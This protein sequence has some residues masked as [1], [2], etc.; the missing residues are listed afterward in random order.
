MLL[1]VIAGIAFVYIKP[2]NFDGFAI[3]ACVI[4]VLLVIRYQLTK[5]L[6]KIGRNNSTNYAAN[7]ENDLSTLDYSESSEVL[8]EAVFK[9]FKTNVKTSSIHFL[10]DAG[11]E[12]LVT[13]FSSADKKVSVPV[14]SPIFD[15]CLNA[16]RT[17]VFKSQL[18]S[19]YFLAGAREELLKLF[20][21]SNSEVLI[22]L[23]EGY[24]KS[25]TTSVGSHVAP[26][27]TEISLAD[28]SCGC[29]FSSASTFG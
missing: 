27:R 14:N 9:H 6:R 13:L 25:S 17:I 19:K 7:F 4:A 24:M 16:N 18:T 20:E 5:L 23:T 22:L 11:D 3:Y 28:K 29:T 26:N 15:V 8:F 1:G 21:D 10:I 2:Q 12:G